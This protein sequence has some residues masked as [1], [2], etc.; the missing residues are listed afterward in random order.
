M[1]P[2][3]T[4]ARV[5]QQSRRG[6]FLRWATLPLACFPS[7]GDPDTH[8]DCGAVP[9]TAAA[10][11]ALRFFAARPVTLSF[12]CVASLRALVPASLTVTFALLTA[13]YA[14]SAAIPAC[15]TALAADVSSLAIVPS[16]ICRIENLLASYRVRPATVPC[17]G[18]AYL[19]SFFSTQVRQTTPAA[20]GRRSGKETG[21][22]PR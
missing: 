3:K 9:T 22:S 8:R 18:F 15:F 19:T 17:Q 6:R 4:I 12:I 10:I 5:G 20:A 14:C 21:R 11:L 7:L 13:S 2:E 16:L 1:S